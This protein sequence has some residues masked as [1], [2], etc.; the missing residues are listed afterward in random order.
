MNLKSFYLYSLLT[1]GIICIITICI[2]APSIQNE[3]FTNSDQEEPRSA[4][5][6][7]SSQN[8]VRSTASSVP[9]RLSPTVTPLRSEDRSPA[10]DTPLTGTN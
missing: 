9:S 7:S 3:S 1:I 6:A 2:L 10:N 8:D 4:S 5:N